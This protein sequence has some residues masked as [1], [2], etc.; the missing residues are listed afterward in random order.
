MG[1][2][3]KKWAISQ[4]GITSSNKHTLQKCGNWTNR[5]IW[6]L[7]FGLTGLYLPDHL[8]RDGGLTNCRL[9]PAHDPVYGSRLLVSAVV[10]TD[11]QHLHVRILLLES[12]QSLFSPLRDIAHKGNIYS[13]GDTRKQRSERGAQVTFKFHRLWCKIWS[14]LG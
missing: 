2:F 3:S 1:C 11:R 9:S 8:G 5:Q 12:V 6:S 13:T 14:Y 7:K 10:A 4:T